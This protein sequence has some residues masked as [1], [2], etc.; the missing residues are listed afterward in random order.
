MIARPRYH[1]SAAAL[2]LVLWAVA[3]MALL[4]GGLSFAIRQDLAVSNLR[5]DRLVAHWLARA[6]V[7]RAIAAVMD[8]PSTVDSPQDLWSDDTSTMR[9]V[10]LAGGTFSVIHGSPDATP[11]VLYGASDE[12]GKLN[13]NVATSEQLMALPKMTESIAAAII[14]WRDADDD[15][16]PEGIESSHYSSLAHPYTI[17]NAPLRSVRELLLV[18]DV[19]PELFYGEDTNG[20][21]VLDPNEDDGE[22]SPPNDNR[23]GRLDRGW[24][25]Y[26][27]VY[28]YE[29]NRSASGGKRLNIK[30]ANESTLSQQLNLESWAAR[31]IVK[32]REQ[33]AFEHLVDLLDVKKDTSGEQSTSSSEDINNR[34]SNEKDQPVTLAMFKEMVD[35]I[36][37]QDEEMLAGRININTACREVIRA[38][39]GVDDELADAIVE[40]RDAVAGFNSI[41]ELLDVSG[42]SKEKFA[43]MENSVTVRS[44][45]FRIHGQGRSASGL[46]E[47]TIECVVDRGTSSPRV[48]YWLESSP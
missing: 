47:A 17:R 27:T 8:D 16:Q 34:G 1:R 26:L 22:S 20:N 31:S 33:K 36:T 23:D 28:S 15:P 46:G 14:D 42:I 43:R 7:E 38:L 2:I 40:R 13:V 37:L 32:A 25:A 10:Q 39:P 21:G 48:L 24:I 9:E 6:G 12:S 11:L 3:V 29:L 18:R 5:N 45:V 30:T 44:S 35:Q 4:A 19:T 41:G